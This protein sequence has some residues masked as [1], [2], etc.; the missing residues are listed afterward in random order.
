MKIIGKIVL[1]GIVT[2]FSSF[3]RAQ[4]YEFDQLEMLYDQAHYKMVKRKANRLLD[5]PA[6]DYSVLP[7]FYKS[8][9]LFQLSR[10]ESWHKR[11]PNS[12]NEAK[13]LFI[14]VNRSNKG[15][16]ILRSHVFEVSSLKRDLIS[17]SSDLKIQG[18]EQEFD[19][20]QSILAAIFKNVPTV[21]I[22]SPN[23]NSD[24][25]KPES[26][27]PVVESLTISESRKTI[28]AAANKQLGVPYKW[29]GTTPKGFDCSGFTGY[30]LKTAGKE[31]P[32]RAVDQHSKATKVKEKN[33][34]PGDLVFFDGGT[35]ISH[36]GIIYSTENGTL[37]MIHASSSKGIS[38]VDIRTSKYWKARL[39]SFGTYL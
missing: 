6:Y 37:Q 1:V 16:N 8:L 12:L 26:N 38:I 32:R 27:K 24:K 34:K 14:E 22:V 18:K 13:D 10:N 15:L 5:D 3:S 23:N 20:I 39:H 29:A 25:E 2:L 33:V 30:A 31:I 7:K 4:V 28:L 35:G 9:A 11:N 36:V 19:H 17:W 21:D